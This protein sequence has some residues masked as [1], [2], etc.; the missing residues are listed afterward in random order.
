M[1][2]K[3]SQYNLFFSSIQWDPSPVALRIPLINIEIYWYSLFFAVGFLLSCWIAHRFLIQI[4]KSEKKFDTLAWYI[5]LGMLLGARLGHVLL[6]DFSYYLAHPQEI[7]MV[8]RGG[9]AS[10][11]G[12]LGML[13]AIWIFSKRQNVPFLEIVDVIAFV[14][15]L[16]G[17]FIRIGNFF[18][19]EII[20]TPSQLPWAIIF[21]HP[22]SETQEILSSSRHPV[23][24][25]EALLYF[26][27]FAVSC[28]IFRSWISQKKLST[29]ET[30]Q[31]AVFGRVTGFELFVIF[32]GRFLLEYCKTSQSEMDFA[33]ISIGQIL[34]IP[35]ILVG[36]YLML[37][38]KA[39]YKKS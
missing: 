39:H 16:A 1:M 31:E 9:L 20:G 23:Q 19:Q 28:W 7:I 2:Q 21:G 24:L 4:L 32:S 25:Y 8:W 12:A 6:Y 34:S 13:L 22:M 30:S 36:A 38:T 5:F 18:N 10:H 17:G 29:T 26:L 11:G 15:P 35:F 33:W 14:T 3:L 37:R 27:L